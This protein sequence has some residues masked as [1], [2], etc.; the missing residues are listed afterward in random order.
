MVNYTLKE[1]FNL[2]T[3]KENLGSIRKKLNGKK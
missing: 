1:M 3:F 2:G